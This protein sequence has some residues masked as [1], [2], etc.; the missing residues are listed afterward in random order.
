MHVFLLKSMVSR[1][2]YFLLYV[3]KAQNVDAKQLSTISHIS[4]GN[5]SVGKVN[6]EDLFCHFY[7]FLINTHKR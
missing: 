7:L 6:G 5:I 3:S 4:V 2:S 1:N